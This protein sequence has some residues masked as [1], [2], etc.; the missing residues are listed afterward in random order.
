MDKQLIKASIL[1][2]VELEI[3]AWLEAEPKLTD[4]F[5]YEK[6]LFERTLRIGQVM[7]EQGQGKVSRDRNCKKK[8]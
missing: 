1:K 5:E 7:L 4:P 6:S 3:D 8:S 2:T